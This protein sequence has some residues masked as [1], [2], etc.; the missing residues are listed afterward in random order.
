MPIGVDAGD[1]IAGIRGKRGKR[2]GK[3]HKKRIGRGHRQLHGLDRYQ[4]GDLQAHIQSGEWGGGAYLPGHVAR[5]A[6]SN[7][8]YV[9]AMLSSALSQ[10]LDLDPHRVA[11]AYELQ[12]CRRE[13][14]CAAQRRRLPGKAQALCSLQTVMC[15]PTAMSPAAQGTSSPCRAG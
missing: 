6:W 10:D 5:W 13:R 7:A 14:R 4:D 3:L 11:H 15:R 1:E 12:T 2:I 8:A 9:K